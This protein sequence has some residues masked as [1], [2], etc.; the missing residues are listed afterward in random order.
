VELTARERGMTLLDA[1]RHSEAIPQ[2]SARAAQ[3][4]LQFVRL[5]DVIRHEAEGAT[6]TELTQAVIKHSGYSQALEQEGSIKSRGKLEN[7]QELL[8]A[9]REYEDS[10]DEPTIAG[11][12]E[13]VALLTTAD[14]I[15]EGIEAVPLMTLHSAKGLEF[16]VVFLVG[17]EEALFPLARAAFS[18]NPG[19]LEEERRLCY[20]GMTRAKERLFL[21]SAEYRTLYGN[22]SRTMPSRFL[23]D[24]PDELI[25]PMGPIAPRYITWESADVARSPIAQQ[26]LAEAGAIDAPFRAGDRVRHPR[27]GQGMVVSVH[28]T[29]TD[30]IVSVAFP[31]KG[32]KKL[33]PAYAS[34]EKM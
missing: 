33:D 2:L 28:G 11:F 25:E 19:E 27:F 7:I 20:V 16:P 34:L 5:M 26:V 31:A 32:I 12:L 10:A 29:G 17:V 23:N 6:L 30:M 13:N 21:T 24:I 3:A 1:A 9:T 15:Q 4:V 8:S 18:D 22:T 14:M